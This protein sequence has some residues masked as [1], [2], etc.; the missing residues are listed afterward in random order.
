MK[1]I[2]IINKYSSIVL[3]K[4]KRSI[5]YEFEKYDYGKY[6]STRVAKLSQR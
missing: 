2:K 5:K 6:K 3:N 1:K 4:I